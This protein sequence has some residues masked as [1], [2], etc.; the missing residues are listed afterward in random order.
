M[1]LFFVEL[2]IVVVLAFV[3][4]F[5]MHKIKQPLLVG[6]ILTGV[7]AGPLFFN[8]LSSSEGYQTFSHIGVALLRWK[9]RGK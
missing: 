6:Y 3:V 4:S 7:L 8:I 9:H 5:F 2:S 1:A